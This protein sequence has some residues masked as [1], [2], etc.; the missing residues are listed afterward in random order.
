MRY[1]A[2]I[3]T[4]L[5]FLMSGCSVISEE[6][7][8]G[9][10]RDLTIQAV[11]ANPE[12]HKGKKVIWGGMILSLKNLKDRTVIQVLHHPLDSS[13]RVLTRRESSGRF[14]IVVPGYLDSEIYKKEREIIVAATIEGVRVEKINEMDYPY[15]VLAPLQTRLF[16][17]ADDLYTYEPFYPWYNSPYYYDPYYLDPYFYDYPYRRPFRRWYPYHP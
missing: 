6:I 12:L 7:R 14:L 17:P 9:S 13:D 10:D 2:V 15:P 11:Q 16:D 3:V 8:R 1:G 4:L 5:I